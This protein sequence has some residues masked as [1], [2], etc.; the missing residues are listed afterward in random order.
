MGK[1][2]VDFVC[3][4]ERLIVELDGGQHNE[5]ASDLVRDAWLVAQ[6]FK[7]LRFW[8][9]EVFDNLE[10]VVE[11]VLAQLQ[12]APSPQPLSRRGRGARRRKKT[13]A[14]AIAERGS[15]CSSFAS[16]PLDGGGAEGE[17]GVPTKSYKK[18]PT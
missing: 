1:Y 2:I 4:R 6:G 15:E 9:N 7:V 17:G 18:I 14:N 10:G 8:N 5:S 12:A 11:R 3:L 13:T 16:L